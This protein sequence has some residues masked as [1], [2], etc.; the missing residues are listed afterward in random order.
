MLPS[1][2]LQETRR[3][4]LLRGGGGEGIGPSSAIICCCCRIW[5]L[6]DP[7]RDV[8]LLGAGLNS[9]PLTNGRSRSISWGLEPETGKLRFLS[10]AFKSL[11]FMSSSRVSCWLL[12]EEEFLVAAVAVEVAE[13]TEEVE[14]GASELLVVVCG[15][16]GADE[17][18][19]VGCCAAVA[20]RKVAKLLATSPAVLTDELA[21]LGPTPVALAGKMIWGYLC[22]HSSCH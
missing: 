13:A 8:D 2:L 12:D 16:V 21:P 17:T 4:A 6:C 3:E 7:R 10:S 9:S 14:G 15:G 20:A 1:K 11:T 18:A 19:V 5:L 22:C